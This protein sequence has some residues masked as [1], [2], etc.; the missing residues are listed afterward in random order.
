MLPRDGNFFLHRVHYEIRDVDLKE[1][2]IKILEWNGR[3]EQ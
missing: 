1:G 3:V 2:G